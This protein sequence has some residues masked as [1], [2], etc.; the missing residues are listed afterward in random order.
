L[1]EE[2]RDVSDHW[3]LLGQLIQTGSTAALVRENVPVAIDSVADLAALRTVNA[4]TE[5]TKLAPGDFSTR[6]SLLMQQRSL[7]QLD[8]ELESLRILTSLTPIN[9]TQAAEI[10]NARTRMTEIDRLL[11]AGGT[12][13]TSES[14]GEGRAEIERSVDRSIASGRVRDAAEALE[15]SLPASDPPA[16]LAEKLFSLRL[17]LGQVEEARKALGRISD[18]TRRA[19]FGAVTEIVAARSVTDVTKALDLAEKLVEDRPDSD[20]LKFAVAA[21][22]AEWH[23]EAGDAKRARAALSE[24]T[25]L[26]INRRRRD[27]VDRMRKLVQPD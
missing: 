20:A 23:A 19:V 4:L 10:E 12:G 5:A 3:K 16:E 21:L 2:H 26:A 27:F 25:E 13:G 18:E 15:A 8:Q 22:K 17:W 6:Y 14:P 24:A 7:K 1:I 9:T 11:A